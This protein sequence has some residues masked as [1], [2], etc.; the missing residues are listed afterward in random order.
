M[1]L[2]NERQGG[3]KY[4]QFLELKGKKE[5]PEKVV[6]PHA[7]GFS[8]PQLQVLFSAKSPVGVCSNVHSNQAVFVSVK[9]L[10]LTPGAVWDSTRLPNCCLG[11]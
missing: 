3:S 5:W 6:S 11:I 10:V 7:S 8:P 1:G 2:F 9:K 4:F